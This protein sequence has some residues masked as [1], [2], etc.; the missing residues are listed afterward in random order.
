MI[1]LAKRTIK[2]ITSTNKK[3]DNETQHVTGKNETRKKKWNSRLINQ[4]MLC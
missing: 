4:Y 1:M 3:I 2:T